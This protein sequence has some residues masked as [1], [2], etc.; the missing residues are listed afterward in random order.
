MD[1]N[2]REQAVEDIDVISEKA[3]EEVLKALEEFEDE[4][5]HHSDVKQIKDEDGK[6]IWRLKIKE[7]HTDHRAFIDYIDGEFHVLKVA[8]RDVAYE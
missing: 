8:H 5:F 2:L 3:Q 7:D 1:I 4:Q 6:W